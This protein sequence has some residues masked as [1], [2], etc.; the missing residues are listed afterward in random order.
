MK[1]SKYTGPA[2]EFEVDGKK[3]YIRPLLKSALLPG[4]GKVDLPEFL[5]SQAAIA[6]KVKALK[7]K[8]ESDAEARS[9]STQLIAPTLIGNYLDTESSSSLFEISTKKDGFSLDSVEE[10]TDDLAAK[11]KEIAAL[12]AKIAE[13]EQEST[14]N[15]ES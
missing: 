2:C 7:G 1:R 15:P 10:A 9:L 6:K 11:D 14:E 12:K 4:Q 13:L 3:V 8:K 5:K